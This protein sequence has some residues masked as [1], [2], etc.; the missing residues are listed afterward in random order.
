MSVAL[1]RLARPVL[2]VGGYGYGNVGDEAILAGLLA[3]LGDKR[4]TVVSRDPEGTRRLHGVDAIGIGGAA[5]ALRRHR[6]VIIGGGGLFGR[7]MGAIGRLLPAFGLM[8]AAL[9]REVLVEGV[10][11]DARL[12]P[13]ARLLVPALMRRAAHVSVR[14]SGSIRVLRDW[15]VSADLAPDLSSWMPGHRWGRPRAASRRGHRYVA[16]GHGAGADRGAAGRWRGCAHRRRWRDGRHAGGA[17]RVHA[18]E[19]PSVGGRPRR[20][21]AC[22]RLRAMRPRLAV[23]GEAAHPSVVLA[24]FTQLT[25]VVAMRYHAMLFA[26]R[27]GVP[28][29]PIAYAE[30]T[31]RWLAERG[32]SPVPA[33]TPDVLAALRDALIRDGRSAPPVPT[34]APVPS[35]VPAVLDAVAS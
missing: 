27:A 13:S 28:L 7:D 15:G 32:R 1:E 35:T 26:E 9:G 12:S 23:V 22:R 14:D 34:M 4:V 2:V 33:R 30:K 24:A 20:P 17:V 11:L 25:A 29:V 10:D 5:G 18:D 31:A 3:R 6:A 8:A 19:P 21:R 16:A